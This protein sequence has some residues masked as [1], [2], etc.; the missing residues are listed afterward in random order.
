MSPP[1]GAKSPRGL[2]GCGSHTVFLQEHP[3]LI[4]ERPRS[5][6]FLLVVNVSAKGIQIRRAGREAAIAALTVRK[7][8]FLAMTL[9]REQAIVD[10]L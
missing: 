10:P 9:G 6:M 5:V 2:S 7:K 3:K 4:L 1:L 8:Q